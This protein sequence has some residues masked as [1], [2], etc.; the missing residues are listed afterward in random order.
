MLGDG[1]LDFWSET[2]LYVVLYVLDCVG[3][4]LGWGWVGSVVGV[5]VER[6]DGGVLIRSIILSIILCLGVL[7]LVSWGGVSGSCDWAVMVI[8]YVLY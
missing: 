1:C 5:G 6:W 3:D 8:Y 7:Q 2:F 4:W